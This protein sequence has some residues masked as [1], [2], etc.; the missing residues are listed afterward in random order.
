MIVANKVVSNFGNNLSFI[1]SGF[2]EILLTK[3][4]SGVR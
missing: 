4:L 2:Y 3:K 1:I